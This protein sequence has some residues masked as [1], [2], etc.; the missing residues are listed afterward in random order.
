MMMRMMMRGGLRRLSTTSRFQSVVKSQQKY[1]RIFGFAAVSSMA[2]M[3]VLAYASSTAELENES[4]GDKY[5]IFEKCELKLFTGNAHPELA[6]NIAKCLDIP[7]NK[8]TVSKFKNGESRVEILHSVRDCDVY[9][10]QPTCNP[11]PNDYIMELVILLDAFR[12]AGAARVTAIIPIFGYAR[13]D[14]KDKSRAPISAKV[15]ADILRTAGVGGYFF[16]FSQQHDNNTTT[17]QN[18][19]NRSSRDDRS[20]C[21]SNSRF[22]EFSDR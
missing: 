22:R 4:F 21:T 1:R 14:R 3:G 11:C 9:V 13:Q 6:A 15:I 10:I 16:F 5:S 2:T 17:T 20:S 12:R 7:V 18:N 8:A 19:N